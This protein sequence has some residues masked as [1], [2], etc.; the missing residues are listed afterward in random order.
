MPDFLQT[1]HLGAI[2]ATLVAGGVA[3][4]VAA[5]L[6]I[7][8][9][10]LSGLAAAL[11]S[12]AVLLIVYAVASNWQSVTNAS[13]G[14]SSIP[15]SASVGSTLVWALV[16]IAVAFLFQQT[17]GCLRLRAAREDDIAARSIGVRVA[18]E[19]GVAF[20]VSAFFVGVGGALFAQSVG[21]IQ[22]GAF[23]LSIT[24]LTLAM[25]VVGGMTSLSGAV[26]GTLVLS[27]LSEVLRRLESGVDLGPVTA[28]APTGLREIGFALSMLLILVFRPAGLMGGR[29]LELPG[30]LR[31][32]RG[33][34][35]KPDQPP[36]TPELGS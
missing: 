34:R 30:F 2:P 23:Y 27:T 31:R 8:L 3:A 29:E 11:G 18:R 9:M 33:R 16:G 24:F 1:A 5:F 15:I 19:R 17:R 21:S 4:A 20:V 26:V 12:F 14:M 32:T 22:P 7:P 6:A 25:L 28:N 10:R 36:A 13:A 35:T